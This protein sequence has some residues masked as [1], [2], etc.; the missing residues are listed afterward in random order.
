MARRIEEPISD[1]GI[2]ALTE[3]IQALR[4][5]V[6]EALAR[7]LGGD[8]EDYRAERYLVERESDK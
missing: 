3:E 6:R 7:D 4:E 8:P 2:K 1:D 5:E